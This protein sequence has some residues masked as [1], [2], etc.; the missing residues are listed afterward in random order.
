MDIGWYLRRLRRMS[1]A[2]IGWRARSAT[3][4]RLWRIAT[5]RAP[6]S[7]LQWTGVA[8][9]RGAVDP[10][11]GQRLVQAAEQVLAGRCSC[12]S[13]REEIAAAAAR[14]PVARV[15]RAAASGYIRAP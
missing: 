15:V 4:Q 14:A 7:R 1:P 3:L 8:L 11:A 10:A 5:P 2:E 9:A 13:A 12:E 6:E